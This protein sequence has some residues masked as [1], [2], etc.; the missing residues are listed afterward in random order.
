[1]FK[2]VHGVRLDKTRENSK[3]FKIAAYLKNSTGRTGFV[4]LSHLKADKINYAL[5]FT[6]NFKSAAKSSI[7]LSGIKALSRVA[8]ST[9]TS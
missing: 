5:P 8:S 7:R 3:S 1:M 4:W 6:F 2:V 9:K